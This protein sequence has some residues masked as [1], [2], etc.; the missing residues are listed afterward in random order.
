METKVKNEI[1][2]F[3]FHSIINYSKRIAILTKYNF[4]SYKQKPIENLR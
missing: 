3:F 2:P 1:F 4:A